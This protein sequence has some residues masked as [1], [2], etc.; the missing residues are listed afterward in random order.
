M[1]FKLIKALRKHSTHQLPFLRIQSVVM[2]RKDSQLP[3]HPPLQCLK[4]KFPNHSLRPRLVLLLS[5]GNFRRSSLHRSDH[6]RCQYRSYDNICRIT[7]SR[8]MIP[9]RTMTRALLLDHQPLPARN[10]HR[11]DAGA[12]LAVHLVIC[13]P[14]CF[15]GLS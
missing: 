13:Y 7:V 9:S 1:T 3:I 6:R 14:L 12:S 11:G 4:S 10:F 5:Y 2:N 15:G 8:T